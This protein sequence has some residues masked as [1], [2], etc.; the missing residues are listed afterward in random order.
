MD[1]RKY[2]DKDKRICNTFDSHLQDLA[3]NQRK[4]YRNHCITTILLRTKAK[5]FLWRSM[6][7]MTP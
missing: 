7:T 2:Q 3:K 1:I 5:I 4:G 6:T